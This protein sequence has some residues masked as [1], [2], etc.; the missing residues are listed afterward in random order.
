MKRAATNIAISK[1]SPVILKAKHKAH[2]EVITNQANITRIVTF[3]EVIEV[4]YHVEKCK[5]RYWF[6]AIPKTDQEFA[7]MQI[8]DAAIFINWALQKPF[9]LSRIALIWKAINDGCAKRE[10][11]TLEPA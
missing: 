7:I 9:P 6:T 1:R 2:V 5:A 8:T 3:L 4:V 10:T 11:A